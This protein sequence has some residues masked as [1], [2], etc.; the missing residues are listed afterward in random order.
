MENFELTYRKPKRTKNFKVGD[1]VHILDLYIPAS[2]FKYW[3]GT[4]AEVRKIYNKEQFYIKEDAGGNIWVT[5]HD[6]DY[7]PENEK[8][9][10]KEGFQNEIDN[11][12][13]SA[14]ANV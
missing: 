6:I 12:F 13:I 4:I 14:I 11:E 10:D 3:S 1:R 9:L 8:A 2:C 5:E 7:M